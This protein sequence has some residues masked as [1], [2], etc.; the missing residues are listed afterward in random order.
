MRK[1]SW[2][3]KRRG[4][5]FCSPAC[6]RGCKE[7][8]FI[9]ATVAADRL[10]RALKGKGWKTRVYENLGWHY[11]VYNDY[12]TVYPVGPDSYRCLMSD[13]ID[14]RAGSRLWQDNLAYYR[15]PNQAVWQQIKRAAD[16]VVKLQNVVEG[17][18]EMYET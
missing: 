2:E 4:A 9:A 13:D 3:A 11:S 7:S 16:V 15:D 5:I 10:L 18:L 6:G 1:Q 14:C 17:V 8:E 12:V